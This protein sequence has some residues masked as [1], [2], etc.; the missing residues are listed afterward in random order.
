MIEIDGSEGGGQILRTASSLAAVTGK[1]VKIENIRGSRPNPGLKEQ[2]LKGLRGIA[3]IS[4]GELEN[5]KKGSKEIIFIPGEKIN[6]DQKIKIETAGS[7][8][9]ILQQFQILAL[10][11]KINL[12]IEGGGTSVKWSPPV[13]Y[14]S[15]IFLPLIKQYGYKGEIK[16]EE[17][18]FYPKGG[19]KVKAQL[20]G[21]KL[22]RINIEDKGEIEK[23]DG[24][25]KASRTLKEQRV[26]ERQKKRIK[27]L[28]K[29]KM[30]K[31]P[32][33]KEKYVKSLS[34]GSVILLRAKTEKSIIGSDQLGEKGKR[35]EKVALEAFEKLKREIDSNSS[36]DIH[37]ADQLIP[38]MGYLEKESMIKT[39]KITQHIKT[40]I[41]T[42]KKILKSDFRI[43]GNKIRC[44]G[45]N[46]L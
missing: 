2:H 10:K 38:Y 13:E 19:G 43:E 24:I 25:S 40:N 34:P 26:A 1:K 18:G 6:Q 7:I 30:K 44:L 41:D 12:V 17:H 4:N 21:K 46:T 36:V 14:M 31:T 27:K 29:E 20:N 23:I 3:D 15:K 37:M 33:I 28:V 16:I 42:T 8:G 32:S 22:K 11:K 35:S 45:R 9:L 5:D 39:R